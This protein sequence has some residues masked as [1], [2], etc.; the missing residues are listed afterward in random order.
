MTAI[1][2]GYEYNRGLRSRTP[3]GA[4]TL[5]GALRW[6]R[7][8]QDTHDSYHEGS[9]FLKLGEKKNGIDSFPNIDMGNKLLLGVGG[10]EMLSIF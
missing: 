7:E 5:H 1:G 2:K 6:A 10:G 8:T 3:E 9:E 4:A